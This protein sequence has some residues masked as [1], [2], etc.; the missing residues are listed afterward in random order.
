[1]QKLILREYEDEFESLVDENSFHQ[2]EA[3]VETMNYEY[4]SESLG[5]AERKFMAV[6][7]RRYE[8]PA[9][10]KRSYQ[11]FQKGP[12]PN[13]SLPAT[14]EYHTFSLNPDQYLNVEG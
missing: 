13:G 9:E 2:I 7:G 14:L 10:S 1:M 12:V 3:G 5:G 11:D 6:H 8:G 4:L